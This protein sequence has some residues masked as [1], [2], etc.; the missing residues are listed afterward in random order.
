[1]PDQA[2]AL[3]CAAWIERRLEQV[4]LSRMTRL[5]KTQYAELFV[6]LAPLA[7]LSAKIKLAYA[8]KI[9]GKTAVADLDIIKDIRNQFAHSFHPIKFRT[10]AVATACRRLRMPEA[11]Y[12]R[13]F[14][15]LHRARTQIKPNGAND[16]RIR[17]T[18]TCG[19]IWIALSSRS[20]RGPRPRKAG[21]R[22]SAVLH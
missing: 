9:I 19:F 3:V 6:G 22:V 7:T 18:T 20:M 8:L 10:R 1:M 4:I 2:V 14:T 12:T 16:P 15:D 5:T 17:F 13:A 21:D 11:V